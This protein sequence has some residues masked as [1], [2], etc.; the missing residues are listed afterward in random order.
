MFLLL[1][2]P[3]T[4]NSSFGS[5]SKTI[6]A[7]LFQAPPAIDGIAD[8]EAWEKAEASSGFVQFE[9]SN[10]AP[11]MVHTSVKAGYDEAALYVLFICDDPEPERI[12]SAIT[13]RDGDLDEDDSVAV[14]LDTFKDNN[15]GYVFATNVLGTQLDGRIADNG[16]SQDNRW[17]GEWTSK[18][19]RSD[20]GW[21]VE[22][23]IPFRTI[24][25]KAEKNTVW[26]IN[27]IRIYPRKREVSTWTGPVEDPFRVSQF[28]EL[29][30]MSLD[31]QHSKKY[32]IIPYGLFQA[33][34]HQDFR[35]EAG[36]D[37]RYRLKSDLSAE[38]TINPDFATIEADVEQIN[39]TRFELRIAEK[40]PFFQEGAEQFSQRVTQFYSRRIG[41]IPWGA[42]LMGNMG[43]W[44]LA[45]I[46]VQSDPARTIG[47]T[48][49]EGTNAT[50]G[51][52]RAK[53]TIFGSSNIGFL[54]ANRSWSGSNQGSLGA[55]TTL[56]FSRTLGMTAQ[57]IRAHGP[58]NDGKL[59]W[60]LRPAYDNST[61]HMH[62]RY[63]HYD[64][65]LMKNM[66]A[67]GFVQDDDRREI[68]AEVSKTFWT[69]HAGLESIETRANYNRYWSQDGFLRSWEIDADLEAV[70]RNQWFLEVDLMEE[71]KRFEKD[72][73]NREISVGGG[74]DTRTGRTFEV[75][76]GFGENYESALRLLRG[77]TSLKLTE[78]WDLSYSL[79]R[80]W[81]DPDPED[82]TTWIHVIRSNYYF[83]ND[84]FLKFFYQRNSSIEKKNA[85]A[86]LVWR[87][88]PPFGALQIAYHH[89][90]SRFGTASEQGHTLFT[91]LSW[92]F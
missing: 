8:D 66:N 1:A 75:S 39:L 65:D 37:F 7:A 32:E 14:L 89:G 34:Q 36:V 67:I 17:D 55:D 82:E 31:E 3:I 56:F 79:T 68:D 81:L 84:F 41:D 9:P 78:G 19:S 23:R 44:A 51:I 33:Q 62:V 72:F 69:S 86:T 47:D 5:D 54:A 58:Q 73:R 38:L 11:S 87:F 29:S 48:E 74:Y 85:Q 71:F 90:T 28:G 43:P 42:K 63:S 26:G 6:S 88:I 4:T 2:T 83:Y 35:A 24:R 20:H 70:F 40:R 64:Q 18:A 10:G 92:V 22:F 45:F 27:L 50:Y 21:V 60:F 30:G 61:T 59:A 15:N 52:F 80:L 77:Q 91:K 12:S 13:K 53:R 46:A 49:N 57:F 25:F 76:Y 16:R